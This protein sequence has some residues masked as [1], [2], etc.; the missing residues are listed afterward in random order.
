MCNEDRKNQRT[1]HQTEQLT[2]EQTNKQTNLANCR[3]SQISI[4]IHDR[5]VRSHYSLVWLVFI[6]CCFS[7]AR[8]PARCSLHHLGA[9]MECFFLEHCLAIKLELR[10]S[11]RVNCVSM[12]NEALVTSGASCNCQGGTNQ[13]TDRPL[14]LSAI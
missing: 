3:N 7:F 12:S 4:Y 13:E 9:P 2:N 6:L 14:F 11:I 5:L 8:P 1:N 10:G